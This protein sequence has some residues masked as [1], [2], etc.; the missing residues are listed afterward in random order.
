MVSRTAQWA[1]HCGAQ[2]KKID[3][4][5][6]NFV[7]DCEE[8]ETETEGQ[9][10]NIATVGD[11]LPPAALSISLGICGGLTARYTLPE[12][13]HGFPALHCPRKSHFAMFLAHLHHLG[14]GGS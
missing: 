10:W 11:T 13:G 7:G 9:R 14:W 5:R 3:I 2:E 1:T 12:V 4:C 6:P 8:A